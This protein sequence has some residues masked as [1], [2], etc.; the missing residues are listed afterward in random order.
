LFVF[1][2]ILVGVLAL[3]AAA[4]LATHDARAEKWH[5]GVGFRP[6]FPLI[7]FDVAVAGVAYTILTFVGGLGW[8]GL[9][10]AGVVT[11]RSEAGGLASLLLVA[12]TA[13]AGGG[14]TVLTA[15]LP[16]GSKK[17]VLKRL[18]SVRDRYLRDV[19]ASYARHQTRDH[20]DNVLPGFQALGAKGV[21][22]LKMRAWARETGLKGDAVDRLVALARESDD[23]SL[24]TLAT[25][26]SEHHGGREFLAELVKEAQPPPASGGASTEGSPA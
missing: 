11:P 19:R 9:A 20:V 13:A 23:D 10:A 1:E 4:W 25:D 2:A 14:L 6:I 5:P 15:R 24:M 26:V 17:Q 8:H 7:F 3:S 21:L 18:A 16:A 22:H 12:V